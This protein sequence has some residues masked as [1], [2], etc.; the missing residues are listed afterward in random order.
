[1]LYACYGDGYMMMAP[2][3]VNS[4]NLMQIR[5]T[6]KEGASSGELHPSDW[7]LGKSV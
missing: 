3:L 2:V 4:V 7:P 1:M 5:V 6:W